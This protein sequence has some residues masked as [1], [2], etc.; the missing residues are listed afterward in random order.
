VSPTAAVRA[1]PVA[2]VPMPMNFGGLRVGV[3]CSRLAAVTFPDVVTT[4]A[5]PKGKG[6]SSRSICR[7]T[8]RSSSSCGTMASR[9]TSQPSDSGYS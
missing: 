9:P 3:V 7:T 6:Q 5:V 1:A 4:V 8:C 2:P